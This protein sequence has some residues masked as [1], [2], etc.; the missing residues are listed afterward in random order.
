MT[1]SA[2]NKQLKSWQR[3]AKKEDT[4]YARR[5]MKAKK[6]IEFK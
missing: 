2:E 4:E 6:G 1:Y 5:K 3:K